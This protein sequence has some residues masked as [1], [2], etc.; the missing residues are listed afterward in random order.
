[1][2]NVAQ[3]DD[4]ANAYPLPFMDDFH[5]YGDQFS[6]WRYQ[7]RQRVTLINQYLKTYPARTVLDA[8]AG[9]GP[10][11]YL[12]SK[13]AVRVVALESS[14]E[15]VVRMRKNFEKYP[16]LLDKIEIVIADLTEIPLESDSVDLIICSEVIEH[17]ENRPKALDELRR[18]LKNDGKII[19][20]MPNKNSLYWRRE[21]QLHRKEVSPESFCHWQF[22]AHDIENLVSNAGFKIMETNG[23]CLFLC[24]STVLRVLG[25]CGLFA[26]FNKLDRFLATAIPRC[27]AFYFLILHK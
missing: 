27:S 20:S 24:W 16:E 22:S 25:R 2:W 8:G 7:H 9:K 3:S 23:T 21:K 11:T 17:V 5:D 1:M 4:I 12:A 26:L 19:F 13:V 18:V 15:E 10:N 14:R 6:V